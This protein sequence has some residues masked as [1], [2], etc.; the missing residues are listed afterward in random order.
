MYIYF[1]VINRQARPKVHASR[2]LHL[3]SHSLRF[4]DDV[5]GG[6][7]A[8]KPKTRL[9]TRLERTVRRRQCGGF[10]S[11]VK[12]YLNKKKWKKELSEIKKT[13][14]ALKNKR[15]YWRKEKRSWRIF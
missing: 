4:G 3:P 13:L 5:A 12:N 1:H 14:K 11:A 6:A 8:A 10:L 15:L 7:R 2:R 9:S